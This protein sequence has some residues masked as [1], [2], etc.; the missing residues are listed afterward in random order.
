M[1]IYEYRC[2]ECQRKSSLLVRSLSV[3]PQQPQCESCGS[4]DVYRVMSRFAY[5]RSES[6]RLAEVDTG[7]PASDDYYSD[8]R[9]VGLWAKKRARE[10]GV[11]DVLE[12][13]FEEIVDN[14]HAKVK[15]MLAD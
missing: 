12:P 15:D 1:P 7:K 9:N 11:G 14:A 6:D 13:H 8:S 4:H 5:H 3:Q 2:K 10:L